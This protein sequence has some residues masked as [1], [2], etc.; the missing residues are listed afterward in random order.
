MNLLTGVN[1]TAEA[2]AAE[3]LRMDVI[4]Q[5]I[6]NAHTTRGEDGQPYR[7]QVVSFEAAMGA[8]LGRSPQ[9]AGIRINGIE[10]DNTQ[11][12]LLYNPGHPDAD[13]S[14]MVRMPNVNL[15]FEMVDLVGASRSYEANLSVVRTARQMARQALAI[16]R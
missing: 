11:G 3:K 4:G 9:A 12:P 15:A 13:E 14:G 8:A 16:G 2:L 6:A 5:N 1:V 10:T 7:R